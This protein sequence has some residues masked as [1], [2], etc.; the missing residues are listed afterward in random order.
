[1]SEIYA[2]FGYLTN[3]ESIP[4]LPLHATTALHYDTFSPDKVIQINAPA[5]SLAL[6]RG[7]VAQYATRNTVDL[8]YSRDVQAPRAQGTLVITTL[9]V[10]YTLDADQR[11]NVSVGYRTVEKILVGN[12]GDEGEKHQP[13][14]QQNRTLVLACADSARQY[15]FEFL[16]RGSRQV[17]DVLQTLYRSY[18]TTRFYRATRSKQLIGRQLLPDEFISRQFRDVTVSAPVFPRSLAG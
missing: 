11:R 12:I 10:I 13:L 6:A 7:E 2:K 4:T 5:E 14:V 3:K 18:D 15:R 8:E 9:R 17:F 1:M 16:P